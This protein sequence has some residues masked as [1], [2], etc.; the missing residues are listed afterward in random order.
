[1]QLVETV[2]DWAGARVG[3]DW[4]GWKPSQTHNSKAN[5]R[6]D[7]RVTGTFSVSASLTHPT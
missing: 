5:P 2:P 6:V 7:R 4:I 3:L 1:M